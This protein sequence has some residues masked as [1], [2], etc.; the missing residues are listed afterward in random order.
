MHPF[1]LKDLEFEIPLFAA[2]HQRYICENVSRVCDNSE[3]KKY[4]LEFE[5]V[6]SSYS[7]PNKIK[8]YISI[9]KPNSGNIGIILT[10]ITDSG[11]EI[12]LRHVA[13]P[14]KSISSLEEFEKLLI[15]LAEF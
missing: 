2:K 1:S 15:H 8:L 5:W 4:C 9:L 7:V 6:A 13:K 3:E 14:I 12:R 10:E 11:N